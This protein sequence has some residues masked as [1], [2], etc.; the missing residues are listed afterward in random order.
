M[1][2]LSFIAA[3][4][5]FLAGIASASDLSLDRHEVKWSYRSERHV[6]YSWKVDVNSNLDHA[7][8]V[9]VRIDFLDDDGFV[10]D[11]TKKIDI[12]GKYETRTISDMGIMRRDYQKRIDRTRASIKVLNY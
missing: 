3:L 6:D 10:V 7:V 1:R 11:Y 12:V 4:I 9:M 5:L 2:K 8:R